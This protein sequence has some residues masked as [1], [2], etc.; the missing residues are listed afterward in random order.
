MKLISVLL[1]AI[2]LALPVSAFDQPY[3]TAARNDLNQA[4]NAL[5]RA[6]ADKGGHRE[7]AIS[8]VNQAIAK[9]NAGIAY[10]ERNP[11][12]RP[13]RNDNDGPFARPVADQ[14]NMKLAKGHLQAALD[15]LGRATADKGGYR[16]DAMKL[17]R[18]A[19]SETQ[20]GIDYDRAN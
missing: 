8:L 7:R 11:N 17:I 2:L 19:I 1:I 5:K 20:K 14:P 12:N 4:L 3:M 13:R 6:T 9:V 15:N 16:V 10:D 18:E